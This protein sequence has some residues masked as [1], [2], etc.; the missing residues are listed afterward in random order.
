MEVE[1]DADADADDVVDARPDFVPCLPCLD[2]PNTSFCG[3]ARAGAGVAAA[4]TAP[5]APLA[6]LAPLVPAAPLA[7]GD[8][9]AGRDVAGVATGAATGIGTAGVGTAAIPP[10]S[11]L[12]KSTIPAGRHAWA[13]LAR[14]A[15]RLLSGGETGAVVAGGW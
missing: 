9:C 15:A 4:P 12:S 6:P 2:V 10:S 5:A 1:A 7:L 11:S 13:S 3:P 8:E 14:L